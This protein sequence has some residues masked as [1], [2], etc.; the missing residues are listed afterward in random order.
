MTAHHFPNKAGKK[1]KRNTT[2]SSLYSSL[3]WLLKSRTSQFGKGLFLH[4]FEAPAFLNLNF[5]F[6]L[7]SLLWARQIL[8][9][10]WRLNT[11][12]R[13][14]FSP[15]KVKAQ[16]LR[17]D[18]TLRQDESCKDLIIRHKTKSECIYLLLFNITP[19]KTSRQFQ[20]T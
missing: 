4:F 6:E 8:A 3:L 14:Q 13:I 20:S 1:W 15:V 18:Q 5:D 2:L 19:D 17:N 7:Q 9:C 12:R 11:C 16:M 10:F